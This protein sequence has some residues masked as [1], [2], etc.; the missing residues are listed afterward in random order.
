MDTISVI[1]F[2]ISFLAALFSIPIWIKRAKKIG[3]VGKDVHKI[4]KDKIAEAGGV[5][6]LGGF[7]IGVLSYIAIKTF[8]LK[9]SE[10]L[11][12]IFSLLLSVLII[13]R[14]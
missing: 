13:F 4:S 1:P 8:Y 11:I 7:I 9:S 2:M 3:L 14:M 12:E 6:V 5:V 10:N